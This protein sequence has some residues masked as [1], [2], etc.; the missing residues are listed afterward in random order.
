MEQLRSLIVSCDKITQTCSAELDDMTD[1][2]HQSFLG[3]KIAECLSHNDG[4]KQCIANN[5]A[6]L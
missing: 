6:Y 5:K 3:F 4:L 2:S 1:E